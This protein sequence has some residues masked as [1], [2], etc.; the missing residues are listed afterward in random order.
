[1]IKRHTEI[2]L[3][4]GRNGRLAQFHINYDYTSFT[5]IAGNPALP[6]LILKELN[7]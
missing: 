2:A 3:K 5:N 7:R 4:G 6:G 1:M